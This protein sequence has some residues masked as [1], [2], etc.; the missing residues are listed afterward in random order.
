MISRHPRSIHH[1]MPLVAALFVALGCST[2]AVPPSVAQRPAATAPTLVPPG[3]PFP[4]GVF[5]NLNAT[6]QVAGSSVD[7]STLL[8]HKPVLFCYWIPGYKRS[9]ETLQRLDALVLELGT[10]RIALLSVVKRQPG[11]DT[12][13]VRERIAALGLKAPVLDDND[14]VLGRQLGVQ[15]VPNMA[16]IDVEGRLRLGNAATLTQSLEYKLDVQGA[17]RRAAENGKVGTYGHLDR[18][19]PVQELVGTRCPDFTAPHLLTDVEQRWSRM[20]DSEKL[21]VIVF[22]KVDCPHCR[23]ALPEINAWLQKHPG[24]INLISAAMVDNPTVKTK[25]REFCA[26][27]QFVFPTLSV[28]PKI[29]E[30]FLVT[31]TP[32][33]LIIRPDGVID[34]VLLSD[35]A[36]FGRT[37][38]Q[39]R[40]EVL[41][42]S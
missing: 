4:K 10:E 42:A 14:F 1:G 6:G 8:G 24:S 32:T 29:S 34:S 28:D 5:P 9:E 23:H 19:Y 3:V 30:Q 2:E 37:M 40:R 38:E 27:N 25:T 22:W 16:L 41:G 18:Y 36:D 20:H 39:K 17:I 13:V 15:S 31:S 12:D 26:A 35:Q 33:I 7:L 21:N 11:R